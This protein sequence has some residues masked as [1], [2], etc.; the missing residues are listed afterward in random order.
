M[1]HIFITN[2][3]AGYG[4]QGVIEIYKTKCDVCGI[5]TQCISIDCS[6]SEYEDGRICFDCIKKLFEKLEK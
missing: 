6:E 2:F 5:E 4:R 1:K 3:D